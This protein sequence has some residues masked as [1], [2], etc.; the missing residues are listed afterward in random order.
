MEYFEFRAMNSDIVMAAEGLP[1]RV[2]PGFEATQAFIEARERQLSRFFAQSELSQ[3]NGAAGSWFM[4]SP[5]LFDLVRM[6]RDFYLQTGGLFDPSILPDL[7]RVGYDR[8]M[9]EIRAEGV[10]AYVIPWRRQ[11]IAFDQLQLDEPD[12]QI[13]MPPG[14]KIDLGGIAKGWIAEQAAWRLAGYA[15][16]CAISAGGDIVLIGTPEGQSAWEI[17][18]EDPRDP[19]RSLATLYAPP[20]AVATSSIAKRSWRQSGR[21]RHHLIDPRTGE[22][23]ETDWLSVTVFAPQAVTAEVYAKV[24]LIA[25]SSLAMDIVARISE[26]RFIAVDRQGCLWGSPNSKELFDVNPGIN[27]RSY[28]R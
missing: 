7:I 4:A 5:E 9:D 3:L 1:K 23:A 14:M 17:A 15:A 16:A 13:W 28:G 10:S 21:L 11:K 24:L 19:E 18:L 2:A 20:G 27:T 6:A 12:R 26:A 25:G 8:S 22:P